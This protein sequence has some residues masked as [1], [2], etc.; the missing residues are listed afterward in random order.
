MEIILPQMIAAGIYN[1]QLANK[2]RTVSANRRTTMF[3]IELPIEAGGISYVDDSLHRIQTDTLICAKPNQIR[4]TRLPFKCY[5]IHF[6]L[7]G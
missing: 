2:N 3:E 6:R 7:S 4:H 1:A 5:Y